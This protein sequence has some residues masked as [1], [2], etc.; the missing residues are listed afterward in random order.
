MRVLSLIPDGYPT[1]RPDVVALAGKYLPRHGVQTDL[2]TQVPENG[3]AVETQWGG[4][5]VSACRRTGS[6]MRDQLIGFAHDLRTLWRLPVGACDAIQVRDK[7][8]AAIPALW[9]ARR[10][11]LPFFY[12]MSFPM[13]ERYIA[14][15]RDEGRSV[16]LARWLFLAVKGYL[17]K[18]LLYRYL[19]P[20]CPCTF[21]QSD[22]MA[23]DVASQGIDP[24]HVF[25]VPMG[26]DLEKPLPPLIP[27][28][29][30]HAR[31]GGQRVVA[32]LGTFDRPRKLEFLLEV[33][34]ELAEDIPNVTLLMIGG[35]P[36]A[37]D[38]IRLQNHARTL[39]VGDRIV[40]TGWV[41]S[42]EAWRWLVQADVAVSLF[43]RGELLDSASPTKVVE[44]LALGLPVVAND[45]P[46]QDAVLRGSGAGLS[47]PMTHKAFRAALLHSLSD[48]GF[49]AR[50]RMAG[51]DWVAAH[52][53]YDKLAARVAEVYL[54]HAT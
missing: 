33:L 54:S 24:A 17:G 28:Q 40:W 35:G 43:P 13:S 48:Q 51:P 46:D 22:R 29:A 47:V 26:V 15:V 42:D 18:A 12:W 31:L 10:R 14:V 34:C 4:G 32:Y 6:R 39:G 21:V 44:Y 19:L 7:V 52:R 49:A 38:T 3:P 8:F 1:F 27:P 20:R 25:A 53:S 36:T 37:D 9:L 2:V 11:G 23:Q 50:A 5:Q 30:R 16:G 45:Q 41:G